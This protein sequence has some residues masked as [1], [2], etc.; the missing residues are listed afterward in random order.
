VGKLPGL[1]Q[2][3][4]AK[5]EKDW[6][7]LLEE[8]AKAIIQAIK[9]KGQQPSYEFSI[10]CKAVVDYLNSRIYH[11]DDSLDALTKVNGKQNRFKI[12]VATLEKLK[13]V[14]K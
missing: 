1:Y 8:R 7:V 11:M 2:A 14:M 5:H 6:N 13:E 9:I 4:R 12:M 10:K 3:I